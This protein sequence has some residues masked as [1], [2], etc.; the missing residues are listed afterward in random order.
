[1]RGSSS[2]D[3]LEDAVSKHN[4]AVADE[5][6]TFL[7]QMHPQLFEQIIGELLSRLGFEDIEVTQFTNDQ[8]IDLRAR[9]VVKGVA[10][11][12]TAI[13]VKRWKNNVGS[14]DIQQLRGSLSIIPPE[15]GLFVTLSDFTSSAVAESKASGRGPIT[16]V[17]GNQLISLML[18]TRLGVVERELPIFDLD[19]EF[20]LQQLEEQ[21]TASEK[22]ATTG[23]AQPE[24]VPPKLAP[25]QKSARRRGQ[26]LWPLPGG[27]TSYRISLDTILTYVRESQPSQEEAARWM[28]S[29]FSRVKAPGVVRGYFRVPRVL[30]LLSLSRNHHFL[31]PLGEEYLDNPSDATIARLL[32]ERIAG[33][34]EI[35]GLLGESPKIVRELHQSL[36]TL[37]VL[38]VQTDAQIVWR[39]NWLYSVGIAEPVNQD[40]WQ[41]TGVLPEFESSY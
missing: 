19:P 40:L 4:S 25:S 7:L 11:S 18:E 35:Y 15:N 24:I 27:R 14:R 9:L 12:I 28:I 36:K 3:G 2:L 22:A 37:G 20:S 33:V 30:G 1:M 16:L 26:W 5:L 23:G 8:G 31:T 6:R 38:D 29:T 34:E 39:L 32:L 41:L 13:Q 10:D 17:N 21:S